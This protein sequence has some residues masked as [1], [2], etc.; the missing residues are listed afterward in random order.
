MYST[1]IDLN[2][3]NSRRQEDWKTARAQC[4]A[5]YVLYMHRKNLLATPTVIACY[6]IFTMEP[7]A[8]LHLTVQLVEASVRNS[9]V[10]TVTK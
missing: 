10:S 4:P 5:W 1:V 9:H 7:H 2:F 6:E 3:M 8:L